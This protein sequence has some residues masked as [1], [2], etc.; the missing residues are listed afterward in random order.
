MRSLQW[1]GASVATIWLLEH[2]K[3]WLKYGTQLTA[4]SLDASEGI[5]EGWAQSLGTCRLLA[6][7]AVTG[8]YSKETSELPIR[9]SVRWLATSKKCAVL[10]G[11]STISSWPLVVTTINSFSG[12]CILTRP[13]PNSVIILQLLKQL[14]GVHTKVVCWRRAEALQTVTFA[15]GI[16]TRCS[17]FTL[18]TLAAKFAIWCL[19][20]IRKKSCRLTATV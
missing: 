3:E 10:S 7:V 4:N 11:V 15:F 13:R 8:R 20:R 12:H 18:L 19:A 16:R 14:V 9:I 5:L 17:L 2:I 6:Q 1:A